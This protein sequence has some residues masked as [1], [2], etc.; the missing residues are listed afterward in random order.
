MELLLLMDRMFGVCI[1]IP[2]WLYLLLTTPNELT[3]TCSCDRAEFDSEVSEYSTF[4]ECTHIIIIHLCVEHT[5]HISVEAGLLLTGDGST[6]YTR[7]LRSPF[8]LFLINTVLIKNGGW[9]MLL[10]CGGRGGWGCAAKGLE[11]PFPSVL[12]QNQASYRWVGFPLRVTRSGEQYLG[13][14][15]TN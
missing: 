13:L 3:P 2:R 10:L 12:F 15:M 5:G 1:C 7:Y 8:A 9:V 11:K 6:R 14:G 4:R